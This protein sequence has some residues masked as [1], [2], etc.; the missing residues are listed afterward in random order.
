MKNELIKTRSIFARKYDKSRLKYLELCRN[1]PEYKPALKDVL[2]LVDEADKALKVYAETAAK[3]L[4]TVTDNESIVEPLGDY[5][6]L[7]GEVMVAIASL[8]ANLLDNSKD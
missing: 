1:A 8:E 3:A 2:V 7:M 4:V 5:I 6:D